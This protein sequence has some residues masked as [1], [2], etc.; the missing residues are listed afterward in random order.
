[1]NR[2][3]ILFLTNDFSN[4][5]SR[6]IHY[7]AQ[8]LSKVSDL[9]VYSNPGDINSILKTIRFKPD[10]ILINS[11][12]PDNCPTITE[13]SSINIPLGMIMTDLHFTVVEQKRFIIENNIK[14]LFSNCR[15]AFRSFYPEFLDRA[16]WLPHFVNIDI[17]KDYKL[18]KD[19]D[20]LMMGNISSKQYGFR[21]H[22]V[23]TMNQEPGF[24]FHP[25][26]GYKDADD[27]KDY[28]GERYAR[29]INRSKIFLTED[30]D[31]HYPVK[32]YYE[33]TACKTLLLAPE[34][35]E[36]KDLGF[37]SGVNFISINQNDFLQKARYYLLHE[38][39]R[40]E[41]AQRGY[42]MVH[43]RHSAEKRISQFINTLQEILLL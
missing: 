30:S 23:D 38:N 34:S 25:H 26:P 6:N 35:P 11:T 7:F 1:M 13:L 14:F 31:Y 21:R 9:I 36:L 39:E 24:V 8:E 41:I 32:K 22:M 43:A 28:V 12:M 40:E 17:F 4:Y 2:I 3:K 20:Y 15:D 42:E 16:Y 19:I 10:F 33:V 27:E 37:I 29:E 5:I 18:Q